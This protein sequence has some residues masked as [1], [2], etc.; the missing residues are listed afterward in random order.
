VKCT[1]FKETWRRPLRSH[2]KI[3]SHR[4]FCCGG[5]QNYKREQWDDALI[6]ADADD[7][8]FFRYFNFDFETGG[9]SPNLTAF[10]GD[11]Q[12]AAVTIHIYGLDGPERRRFRRLER[13]QCERTLD[14]N[15]ND[16]GYQDFVRD[17]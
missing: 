5:C 12:G 9:I 8:E 3:C 1:S 11:Q 10:V 17:P 14:P 6:H 7:F 4:Y 15:I 2:E 13:R 16:F